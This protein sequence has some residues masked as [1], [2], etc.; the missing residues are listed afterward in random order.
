MKPWYTS[1]TLYV[2][3]LAAV[4]LFAQSQLGF[5]LPPGTEAY[6]LIVVNLILRV[7]TKTGLTA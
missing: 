6:V 7:I 1:R 3:L 5:A 4:A 2:N